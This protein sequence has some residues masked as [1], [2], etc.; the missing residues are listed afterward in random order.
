MFVL[1]FHNIFFFN[2]SFF[3]FQYSIQLAEL[4]HYLEHSPLGSLGF[5]NIRTDDFVLI[6]K[7]IKLVDL[8]DFTIGD[9]KC[10]TSRDC[11]DVGYDGSGKA[12]SQY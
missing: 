6:D 3:K 12:D 9:P 1:W 10:R 7:N 5:G 4:L 11:T 8:D 2:V